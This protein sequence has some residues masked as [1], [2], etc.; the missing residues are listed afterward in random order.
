M[1]QFKCPDCNYVVSPGM[2]SCPKCW[3]KSEHFLETD[4]LPTDY[5][6]LSTTHAIEGHEIASY[7][8]LVFGAGNAAW[9]I[10]GTAGKANTAL[11][12]AQ[13][14]LLANARSLKGDAVVG[15]THSMDGSG[16]PLNRSQTI[17][18]SG[19]AV[20]LK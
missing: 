8:G 15:I 5:I 2:E 4:E 1:P 3:L 18:L 10:E 7:L 16:N 11:E 14:E 9:T 13:D 19:T 17:T 12:K 6:Y 20:K